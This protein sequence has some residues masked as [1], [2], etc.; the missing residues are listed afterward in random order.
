MRILLRII[1]VGVGLVVVLTTLLIVQLGM[2]GRLMALVGSGA[3]G[4]ATA[5]GWLMTLSVGPVAAVQ[6]WRLQRIGL[7][8]GAVLCAVTMGYYVVGVVF[9]R[10][11]EAPLWPILGAMAV[12]GALLALL[13]SPAARRACDGGRER[14]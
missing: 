6:L 12:N 8:A 4:L 9:F 14:R 2:S 7:L 11:P 13:L 1:A 10:A 3:L 5:V